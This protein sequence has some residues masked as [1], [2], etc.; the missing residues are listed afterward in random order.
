VSNRQRL[1]T[2]VGAV[3]DAAGETDRVAAKGGLDDDSARTAG[4]DICVLDATALDSTEGMR[5]AG[6]LAKNH[7]AA[8]AVSNMVHAAAGQ[9]SGVVAESAICDC[10]LLCGHCLKFGVGFIRVFLVL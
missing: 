2:S 7:C 5:L 1:D 4:V 3:G 8:I 9:D 6:L 10:K